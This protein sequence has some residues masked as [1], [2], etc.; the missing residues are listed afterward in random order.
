MLAGSWLRCEEPELELGKMVWKVGV[1]R[2][3]LSAVLHACPSMGPWKDLPL[4]LG[5]MELSL[6]TTSQNQPE[7]EGT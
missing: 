6:L 4:S 7:Q 2:G 3:D 5:T 1:L